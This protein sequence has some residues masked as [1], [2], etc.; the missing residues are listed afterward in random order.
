MP[1]EQRER[2]AG[3]GLTSHFRPV[4]YAACALVRGGTGQRSHGRFSRMIAMLIHVGALRSASVLMLWLVMVPA[5][6]AAT[7][8][9]NTRPADS[10][11][12]DPRQSN[13]PPPADPAQ[14]QS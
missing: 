6:H 13:T 9:A 7:A 8:Q 5:A 1:A 10:R 4:R 2:T 3:V 11:P 14:V 12:A